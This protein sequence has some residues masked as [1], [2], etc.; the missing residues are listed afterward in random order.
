MITNFL[1]KF[2]GEKTFEKKVN[3]RNKIYCLLF[4]R[5]SELNF[6][7]RKN[8]DFF[9]TNVFTDGREFLFGKEKSYNTQ[10]FVTFIFPI[11]SDSV[12]YKMHVPITIAKSAYKIIVRWNTLRWDWPF[13][14]NVFWWF[15][16]DLFRKMS[17][18]LCHF[19]FSCKH[20]LRAHLF[21]SIVR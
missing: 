3:L 15:Y 4:S 18:L 19:F 10:I 5:I 2:F 21:I 6:D 13:H 17:Y 14:I 11:P 16:W 9:P 20:K 1:E 12:F 7:L 8:Y